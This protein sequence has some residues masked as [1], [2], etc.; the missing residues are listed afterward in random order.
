MQ[1][2]AIAKLPQAKGIKRQK[3]SVRN[4][5]LLCN[6]DWTQFGFALLSLAT[7]HADQDMDLAWVFKLN[8]T[9][10]YCC[11]MKWWSC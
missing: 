4:S 8:T 7:P 3:Q 6:H 9:K 5:V 11:T 10:L 2:M 1:M